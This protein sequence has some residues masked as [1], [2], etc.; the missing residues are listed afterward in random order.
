[1][2]TSFA[3]LADVHLGNQQYGLSTRFDDFGRAWLDAIDRIVACRVA[4]VIIAGDLFEKRTVEPL[5]L[6]QAIEGLRRLQAAGIPAVAVEGN[7]DRALYGDM[8][9][10]MGYLATEG[11]LVLLD[12][13]PRDREGGIHYRRYDRERTSGSYLDLSGVRII[14]QPYLGAMAPRVLE[15]MAEHLR[16]EGQGD[17]EYVIYAC[18]AGLEGILPHYPGCFR[19]EELNPIRPHVDYLALGHVH[20]QFERDGWV[21]NPGSLE[22]CRSNEAGYPRGFYLVHVDTGCPEKHRAELL[23]CWRRPFACISFA[24]DEITSP[25]ELAKR[26]PV[27]LQSEL[28]G[29]DDP[30]VIELRLTGM[31]RYDPAQLD[32]DAIKALIRELCDPVHIEIKNST[33]LPHEEVD[34]DGSLSRDELEQRVFRELFARDGRYEPQADAWAR[35]ASDIKQIAQDDFDPKALISILA[36]RADELGALPPTAMEARE[37]AHP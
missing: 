24:M 1:M 6:L 36:C 19:E 21:F 15:G 3:H 9:S 5:A 32:P 37:D 20:K 7:H 11:Y 16:L 13:C 35:L 10:W 23:P 27:S 29:W 26:L 4:F 22:T 14:G 30:P 18:H 28:L 25:G 12:P 8:L 31:L 17:A 34:P 33:R 2:Q